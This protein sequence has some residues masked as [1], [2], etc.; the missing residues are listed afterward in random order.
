MN[1]I[2]G[3]AFIKVIIGNKI[4][5]LFLLIPE[6]IPRLTPIISPK[7]NEINTL[8][9]LNKT[10]KIIEVVNNILNILP[11][12]IKKSGKSAGDTIKDIISQTKIIIKIPKETYNKLFFFINR[13]YNLSRN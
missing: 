3:T 6:I 4:Y 8:N 10:S 13:F 5:S 11:S 2:V 1:A 12:D 7:L 9:K